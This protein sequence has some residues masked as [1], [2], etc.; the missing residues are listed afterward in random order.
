[1]DCKFITSEVDEMLWLAVT[2][3]LLL[4]L[5]GVATSTVEGVVLHMLLVAA[6]GVM[7]VGIVQGRK[8]I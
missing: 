2:V 3:F 1:L 6:L 5:L 8:A 7:L 4:W